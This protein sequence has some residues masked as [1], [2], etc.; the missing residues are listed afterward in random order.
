M[1]KSCIRPFPA[2]TKFLDL[3]LLNGAPTQL[4]TL[5]YSTRAPSTV[6]KPQGPNT[7]GD[8]IQSCYVI[9]IGRFTISVT[10]DAETLKCI[11]CL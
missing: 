6:V 11:V 3:V 9:S 7:D 1:G 2:E 10:T 8:A 5:S 4:R